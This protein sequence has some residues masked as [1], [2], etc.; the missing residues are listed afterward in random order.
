MLFTPSMFF[1]LSHLQQKA[2]GAKITTGWQ[3]NNQGSEKALST[4]GSEDRPS[5]MHNTDATFVLPAEKVP[6]LAR[7]WV[8]F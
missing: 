4:D 8:C 2:H 7:V 1:Y 6:G 5:Q 3:Q